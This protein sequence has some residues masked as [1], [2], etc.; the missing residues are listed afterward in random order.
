MNKE[1]EISNRSNSNQKPISQPQPTEEDVR[2]FKDLIKEVHDKN[3]CG[4][5]GGCVSFCS[6]HEL[7]AIEMGPDGKPIYINED[8]CLKCG[9]CY[10]ICPQ[11]PIFD[12]ELQEK[13]NWKPPIGNFQRVA[14]ARATNEDI[15]KLATDGGVVTSLLLYLMSG[16]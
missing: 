12:G 6:A 3:F 5:C 2:S 15:R 4:S 1:T 9:I 14:I 16:R 11:I 8:N 10:F 13:Y 7:K